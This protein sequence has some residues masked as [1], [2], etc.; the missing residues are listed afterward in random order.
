MKIRLFLTKFIKTKINFII[1]LILLFTQSNYSYGDIE[2]A[3]N[4]PKKIR[5]EQ[6]S[7]E[8]RNF[9]KNLFRA[10]TDGDT[11]K[12]IISEKNIKNGLMQ[13]YILRMRIR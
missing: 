10:F 6:S 5:I 7:Q 8:S 13:T 1:L 11:K 4:L 2:F 9:V 12:K 3:K